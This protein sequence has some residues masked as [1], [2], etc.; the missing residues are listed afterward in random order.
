[1]NLRRVSRKEILRMIEI[2]GLNGQQARHFN[3]YNHLFDYLV[4]MENRKLFFKHPD[5][6]QMNWS[7]AIYS[8]KQVASLYTYSKNPSDVIREAFE[9][10]LPLVEI[11]TG[12]YEYPIYIVN[13]PNVDLD[14]LKKKWCLDY[15]RSHDL[16][17]RDYSDIS[18]YS[19][20][21]DG[22]RQS[23]LT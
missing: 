22:E 2:I 13:T 21:R 20:H 1:M 9:D 15:C 14:Y 19:L 10:A 11:C 17:L 3:N 8:L 5:F 7:F 12:N 4:G 6:K 18:S 16:I 23:C